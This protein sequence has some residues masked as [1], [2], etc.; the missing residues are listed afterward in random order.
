[1]TTVEKV[2]GNEV[3][4]RGVGRFGQGDQEDVSEEVAIYLTEGRGDFEIV[5]ADDGEEP[6]DAEEADGGE[7]VDDVD[8]DDADGDADDAEETDGFDVGAFLD[9]N[10]DPVADDI[11]DGEVDDHLDAVSEAADRVGVQDAIGERR[12]ELEG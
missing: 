6:T 2:S 7:E 9:R 8:E 3:V 1:M 4:I 5:D 10:V 12:A 11:R